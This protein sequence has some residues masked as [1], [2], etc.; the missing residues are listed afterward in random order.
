MRLNIFDNI[1][2]ILYGICVA[3]IITLIVIFSIN[4]TD[5]EQFKACYDINFQDSK[6]QRYINY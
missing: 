5:L 6:C 4:Y 1:L 2:V 3:L